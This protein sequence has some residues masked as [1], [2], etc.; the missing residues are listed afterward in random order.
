MPRAPRGEQPARKALARLAV[1]H[2]PP[3]GSQKRKRQKVLRSVGCSSD[4]PRLTEAGSFE[5]G[6]AMVYGSEKDY[7]NVDAVPVWHNVPM[8]PPVK[9]KVQS[10][11]IVFVGLPLTS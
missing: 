10:F 5:R 2:S 9:N 3:P 7:N 1:D 4:P 11:G 8:K 6:S